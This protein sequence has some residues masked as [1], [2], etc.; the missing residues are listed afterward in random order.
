[1]RLLLKLL[2]LRRVNINLELLMMLNRLKIDMNKY[3]EIR[4]KA[5]LRTKCGLEES[6]FMLIPS[7]EMMLF[8]RLQSGLSA[9]MIVSKC[10]MDIPQ[11][12]VQQKT[13]LCKSWKKGDR[14]FM[15]KGGVSLILGWTENPTT[16]L[17]SEQRISVLRMKK[18]TMEI[19]NSLTERKGE[20]L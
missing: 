15:R 3:I 14:M 9:S 12:K 17:N 19:I 5:T 13:S 20:V 1:M 4:E 6:R 10:L 11:S 18:I 16:K 7:S 2:K 8:L